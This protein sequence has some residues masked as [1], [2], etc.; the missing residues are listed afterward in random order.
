MLKPLYN[1]LY[2]EW[3]YNELKYL[4]VILKHKKSAQTSK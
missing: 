3:A 2:I 1:G 4:H